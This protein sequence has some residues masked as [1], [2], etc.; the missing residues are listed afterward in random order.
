MAAEAVSGPDYMRRS[1]RSGQDRHYCRHVRLLPGV[2]KRSETGARGG[3]SRSGVDG[4]EMVTPALPGIAAAVVFKAYQQL[5]E[6]PMDEGLAMGST[7][8]S[9]RG[10]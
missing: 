4:G 2:L 1:G 8:H 5:A 10:R 3:R 9:R 7:F 6:D